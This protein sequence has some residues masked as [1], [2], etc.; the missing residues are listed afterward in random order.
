VRYGLP[1]VPVIIGRS[2]E[3]HYRIDD[4]WISNLHALLEWRG[5]ELWVVDLSSLNGTFVGGQRIAEA[6]V[7]AGMSLAFGHTEAQLQ[8][9]G[10][11]APVGEGLRTSISYQPV[12]V[13]LR[14]DRPSREGTPVTDDEGD[15]GGG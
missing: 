5:V 4:P 13:T 3:A 12:A 6:R 2:P 15:Q 11:A 8:P 9:H 1:G 10:Q 14:S 7:A